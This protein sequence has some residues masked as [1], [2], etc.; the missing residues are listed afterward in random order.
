MIH[1]KPVIRTQ[2]MPYRQN[3]GKPQIEQ[4]AFPVR[5]ANGIVIPSGIAHA[6][7]LSQGDAPA[8]Q[9]QADRLRTLAIATIAERHR[10]RLFM[11]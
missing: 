5:N 7:T 9:D 10:Y 6:V 11:L 1:N 4:R 2:T 8:R 3:R